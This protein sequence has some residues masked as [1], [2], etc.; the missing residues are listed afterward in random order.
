MKRFFIMITVVCATVILFSCDNMNSLHEKYL[1]QGEGIYIGVADSIEVFPGN[2][3]I[4][5]KWKINADPRMTKTVIYWEQRANNKEIPIIRT[6]EGEMW[7]EAQID[8][9]EEA[10]YIF[11]FE[12]QDNR[13]NL[14]VPVEVAGAV[15][16]D[17]F[18]ENLR[19]RGVKEITRL[20]TGETLIVWEG[21]SPS[22]TLQYSIVAYTASN[23]ETVMLTIPNDDDKTMLEGLQTGDNIEIYAVHLPE[24]GL[25]TFNSNR[26]RFVVPRFERL[27]DKSRFEAAFQPGDNTS[28]R[29]GNNTDSWKNTWDI[30]DN[31]DIRQIWDNNTRNDAV[32]GFR[33]IYHMDDMSNNWGASVFKF[34]HCYTFS[35]GV[36]AELT[37]LKFHAR[38]DAGAFTGHSPRYF[39]VW[40]TDVPKTQADFDNETDFETYYR[41]TYVEH[42]PVDNQIQTNPNGNS[43]Y[44]GQEYI[45]PAPAPGI[46]N[47]Q[48][49]WV[50][51]GDFECV[52]PSGSNYNTSNDADRAVWGTSNP[53]G[54][55]DVGGFDF[56]LKSDGKRV[57]YIRLVI[58]YPV[59]QHTNCINIGEVTFWGDDI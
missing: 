16:G 48:E 40:A 54:S 45:Q 20:E 57:K 31:R 43:A 14:S 36:L 1:E 6:T 30:G 15:L 13:G 8:N 18:I 52:K 56:D 49:D 32:N 7:M 53:V 41:T 35:I 22:S 21:V 10:E 58:K 11:I 34:P 12:M 9:I 3:K 47:W 19:N 4:A 5:F 2:R 29:P 59:W 33:G 50:K 28:P 37:R 46:Y 26:R 17:I 44:T 27:I 23:G 38:T 25:E 24:N 42:K 55:L 51:L 39:E